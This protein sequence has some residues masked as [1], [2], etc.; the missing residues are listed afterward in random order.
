MIFV[1]SLLALA[2]LA[3]F[4]GWRRIAISFVVV[5]LLF[6]AALTFYHGTDTLRINW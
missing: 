2:L 5:A 4:V 1:F 6:A 3:L